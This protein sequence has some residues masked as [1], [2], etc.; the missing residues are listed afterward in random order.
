MAWYDYRIARLKVR[1]ALLG[2]KI[3]IEKFI[4]DHFGGEEA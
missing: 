4:I 2:A 1:K 3:C